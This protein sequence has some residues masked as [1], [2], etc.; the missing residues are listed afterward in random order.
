MVNQQ[1]SREARLEAALVRLLDVL[2]E[3][4]RYDHHGYCQT[5]FVENPCRVAEARALVCQEV[6][7][8][9]S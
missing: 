4:C 8:A 5:H 9:Q 6:P 7:D 3:P 2:D 1:G